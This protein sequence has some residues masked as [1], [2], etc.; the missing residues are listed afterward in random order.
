MD[1]RSIM[2]ATANWN[3]KDS[4]NSRNG[5]AFKDK[6]E[7]FEVEK[8]AVMEVVSDE[9]EVDTVSV[10]I[11]KEQEVLT[12]TSTILA[13]T[14]YDII[15]LMNDG[16]AAVCKVVKGKSKSDREFISLQLV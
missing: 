16:E 3:K 15:D 6:A 5:K 10:V 9:G 1:K 14:L 4:I 13:E 7:E 8:A 11:T 12:G 2:A